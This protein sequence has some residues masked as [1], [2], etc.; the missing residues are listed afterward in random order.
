VKPSH[1]D[2]T[3]SS[4]N[5]IVRSYFWSRLRRIAEIAA[6]SSAE[7][8]LDIGCG[9]GQLLEIL[10]YR[11]TDSCSVGI[12]I[13]RDIYFTKEKPEL[14]LCQNV[15]FVRADCAHLPFRHECSQVTFCASVLEHM[16]KVEP[17][18]DEIS[19]T[20]AP[21]G[22]LIVGIPTENWVYRLGRIVVRLRK[23]VDHYHSAEY[24]EP[25]LKRKFTQ[26]RVLKLP[27]QLVPRHLSLYVIVVYVKHSNP[28]AGRSEPDQT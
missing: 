11:H 8:I 25:I 12:D 26:S 21:S 22:K 18:L 23:P 4:P 2:L 10:A 16:L 1:S 14:K 19:A 15:H 6:Q 9:N 27:F 20:L 13:S 24:L 5:P 28:E 17:V 7:V 3:Y